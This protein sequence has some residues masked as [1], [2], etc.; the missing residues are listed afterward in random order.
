MFIEYGNQTATIFYALV[1][2]I[3]GKLSTILWWYASHQN[4]LID[5][6]LDDGRRRGEIW[7][8]L[9][10]SGV[11]LLSIGLAFIDGTLAKLPWALVETAVRFVH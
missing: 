8:S 10:V 3:T 7:G 1:I 11:F 5:P 6:D 4:R 2:T 9:I